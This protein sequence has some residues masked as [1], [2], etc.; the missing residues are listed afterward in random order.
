MGERGAQVARLRAVTPEARRTILAGAAENLPLALAA[1]EVVDVPEARSWLRGED[2]WLAVCGAIALGERAAP[3]ALRAARDDRLRVREGVA[4]GLQRLGERDPMGF[5]E[6]LDG[7][8]GEPDPLVQR[9]RVVA[10]CDPLL[11]ADPA[12]AALAVEVCTEATAVLKAAED[13]RAGGARTLQEAL[14]AAWGL[15]LAA[16]P[17]HGR[18]AF[19]ALEHD[20]DPD[21]VALVRAVRARPG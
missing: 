12:L 4:L 8:R 16:D 19:A 7:W 2:E 14:G 18:A 13:R 21:V 11:L 6:V 20:E 3:E 9:A 17:L 10:I 15:A 5:S 1:A